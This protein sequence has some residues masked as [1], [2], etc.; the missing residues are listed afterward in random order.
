MVIG[1]GNVTLHIESHIDIQIGKDTKWM[2]TQFCKNFK[3]K[4]GFYINPEQY[5]N[6]PS[7]S[8]ITLSHI[9]SIGFYTNFTQ[10][11]TIFSSVFRKDSESE[12]NESLKDRNSNFREWT[13]LLT[14]TVFVWNST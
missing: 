10:L 8:P 13:K 2:E 12:S 5:Y 11:C 6:I 1:F 14:E 4:R 3:N 9:N 7:E